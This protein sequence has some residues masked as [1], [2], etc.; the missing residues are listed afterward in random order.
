MGAAKQG[1]GKGRRLGLA[2][3]GRERAAKKVTA[4]AL[5]VPLGVRRVSGKSV[6]VYAGSVYFSRL[7]F[8][9]TSKIPARNAGLV[10]F[11]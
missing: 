5:S 1:R 4:T 6:T 9:P 11:L 10:F 7:H 8:A 3:G 2:G